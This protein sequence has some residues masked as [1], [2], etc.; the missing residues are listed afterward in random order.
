M[1]VNSSVKQW[2]RCRSLGINFL[3]KKQ[4]GIIHVNSHCEARALQKSR[5]I[6]DFSPQ[7]LHVA[8]LELQIH[9]AVVAVVRCV[10]VDWADDE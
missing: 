1:Q 9:T 7:R 2:G 4:L 5:R 8:Y 6:G 3:S 10:A